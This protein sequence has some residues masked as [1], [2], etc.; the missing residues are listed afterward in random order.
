[1]RHLRWIW[2]VVGVSI[3]VAC[4]PDLELENTQEPQP[5]EPTPDTASIQ[6]QVFEEAYV[7]LRENYIYED[8]GG[9]NWA[10]AGEELR[11]QIELGMQNDEFYEALA[12]MV[13]QLPDGTASYRTRAAR[14]E[15]ETENTDT[16][17]GIGAF[18]AM[19][20]EPKPH[21]ILL[22]V[23]QGSPAEAAGL[24]THDAIYGIDGQ[25]V[26]NESLEVVIESI[27]GPANSDV[28]LE[29]ISP[30]E[31]QREV[32]VTRGRVTAGD[33]IRGGLLPGSNALYFL[34]P[35][36]TDAS[37][38]ETIVRSL[39][40]LDEAGETTP[41]IILDLR[42]A[43]SSVDWPL[44]QMLT[45]FG[46]GQMGISYARQEQQPMV[47]EGQDLFGSQCIPIVILVGPDTRGSP[48]IFAAAMQD[49]GRAIIVGMPTPG[50]VLGFQQLLLV[51]GSELTFARSSFKTES[52]RDL[53]IEG[54]VPDILTTADWD[55][56]TL[57]ND[58]VIDTAIRNLSVGD[59]EEE[60][61]N[62]E[63][64]I[65]TF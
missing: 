57:E 55:Q 1:M 33:I 30:G 48:E 7:T 59:Q 46:D 28:T 18:V 64:K 15:A 29:I 26:P 36:A 45:I 16:Y 24:R 22:S 49:S 27:R 43:Q 61:Q 50:N 34:V 51:D 23:M 41:G 2:V 54:V 65:E 25:P 37:L 56:V 12:A 32:K 35:V 47:I 19:R 3:L 52:G 14:I 60:D 58:P 9:V 21:V 17:E 31:A 38:A 8:Y 13:G 42:I 11:N 5:I 44:F 62:L 6:M 63:Q 53:A 10:A 39:Q 20:T 4:S 40:A